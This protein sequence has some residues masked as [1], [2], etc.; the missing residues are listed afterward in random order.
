MTSNTSCPFDPAICLIKDNLVL[1]A[2]AL[3]SH[4][5]FGI[6][7]PPKSRLH[8]RHVVSCA[9]LVT[10]GFSKIYVNSA[11]KIPL[12]RYYYGKDHVKEVVTKIDTSFTYQVPVNFSMESLDNFTSQQSLVDDYQIG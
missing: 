8:F 5:H 9:P 11:P 10:E 6:N 12:M 3:N 7:T 2:G 1:D 4:E